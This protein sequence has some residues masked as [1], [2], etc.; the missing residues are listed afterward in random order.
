MELT[1]K[2]IYTLAMCHHYLPIFHLHYSDSWACF[3]M[4]AAIEC[5]AGGSCACQRFREWRRRIMN[6]QD[7]SPTYIQ[8]ADSVHGDRNRFVGLLEYMYICN[9]SDVLTMP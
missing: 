9:A 1:W 3:H 5:G 8:N 7:W 2:G 6:L 4:Y